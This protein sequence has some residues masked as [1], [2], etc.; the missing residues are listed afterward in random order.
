[1]S[2][3]K[4]RQRFCD[5][6]DQNGGE[7]GGG[8][9]D[10]KDEKE[11]G[12]DEQADNDIKKDL[13]NIKADIKKLMDGS[14][15]NDATLK[16]LQEQ[17]DKLEDGEAKS[18]LEKIKNELTASKN[19]NMILKLEMYKSKALESEKINAGFSEL[20]TITPEMKTED[21]D[22]LVKKAIEIQKKIKEDLISVNQEQN[23]A[24]KSGDKKKTDDFHDEMIK[25]E[26]EKHKEKEMPKFFR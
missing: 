4:I 24:F 26:S 18:G 7:G 15:G 2:F 1:M 23:P 17:I 13:E 21:I 14:G 25:E 9:E 6:N 22:N 10:E 3:F 16:S 8:K 11:N 5:A 20:I 19:E 12:K